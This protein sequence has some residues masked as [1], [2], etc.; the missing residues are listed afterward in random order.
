MDL[1]NIY[2]LKVSY[3]YV[4][5]AVIVFISVNMMFISSATV[6]E[7]SLNYNEFLLSIYYKMMTL[8]LYIYILEKI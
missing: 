1:F 6:N 5:N 8:N 2:F 7:E 4:N 3:Y